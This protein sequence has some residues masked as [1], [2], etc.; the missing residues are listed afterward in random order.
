MVWRE[1]AA[2]NTIKSLGKA[3]YVGTISVSPIIPCVVYSQPKNLKF[4]DSQGWMNKV[5]WLM[6]MTRRNA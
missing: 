5:S 3:I 2:A 4:W 1:A 6:K